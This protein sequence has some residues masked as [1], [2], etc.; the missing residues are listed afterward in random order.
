MWIR[1]SHRRRSGL[2][3]PPVGLTVA[4]IVFIA[5]AGTIVVA[6]CNVNRGTFLVIEGV[7]WVVPIVLVV[8]AAWTI[9]LE[10]TQFG[11]HVY[12]VGGNA[13]AARRAGI[14]VPNVRTL[15]FILCSL[16]AGIGGIIYLSWQGGDQHEHQRRTARPVRRGRGGHRR[17]QPVRRPRPSDPRC[18]RRPGDRGD[19]QRPVP[20]RP[21]DP[22]AADRDWPRPAG[23]GDR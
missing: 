2:V 11:L 20:A 10:R 21:A 5:V 22:V 8:L 6:I 16:T 23:R 13:E 3:A 9:L 15:G 7:P 18:P 12:A 1:D 17:H 19:L 14:S 4:K